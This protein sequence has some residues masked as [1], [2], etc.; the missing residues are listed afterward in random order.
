MDALLRL[1][2]TGPFAD[3]WGAGAGGHVAGLAAREPD[4]VSLLEWVG[5]L[6]QARAIRKIDDRHHFAHDGGRV[7]ERPVHRPAG[8]E[9]HIARGHGAVGAVRQVMA[10]DVLL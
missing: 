6:Q 3:T 7:A 5:M 2:V 4:E 9:R 8:V 1:L 10:L